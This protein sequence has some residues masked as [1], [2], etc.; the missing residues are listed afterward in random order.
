MASR[1]SGPVQHRPSQSGEA[2]TLPV[3]LEKAHAQDVPGIAALRTAVAER[4]TRDFGHG[5]WSQGGS[6]S[7]VIRDMAIPG[8]Y[9]VRDGGTLIASLRLAAKKPWAIDPAYFTAGKSPLYLTSMAVDPGRQR[10]GVGRACMV[11]ALRV[12]RERS[13]DAI[14][15]D[16]YDSTAGAGGFYEKCGYREVGRVV[17]RNTPLI[18]YEMII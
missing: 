11:D 17:Y 14:R 12:A 9:V 10:Q 1:D 4:L 8:L 15:L 7:G 13:A 3:V 18:Y 6:E 2:L 16:A 5:H